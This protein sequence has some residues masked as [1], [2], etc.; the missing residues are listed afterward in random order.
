MKRRIALLS[1]LLLLVLLAAGCGK[2]ESTHRITLAE[3][4]DAAGY[5]VPARAAAGQ[6]VDLRLEEIT[7]SYY[8]VYVNGEQVP[9]DME[10]SRADENWSH[11]V[12]TMPDEDVE[13]RVE[14]VYADIPETPQG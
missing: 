6:E 8:E 10:R 3:P 4:L 14:T 12:F 5:E 9:M 2:K 11:F 7:E 1:A 13:I